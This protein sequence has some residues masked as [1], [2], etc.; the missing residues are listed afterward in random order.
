LYQNSRTNDLSPHPRTYSR[1][2]I[3]NRSTTEIAAD[4]LYAAVGGAS[5]TK[6]VNRAYLDHKHFQRYTALLLENRLLNY[7]DATKL[8]L[9]T[10]KGTLFLKI[11]EQMIE[12]MTIKEEGLLIKH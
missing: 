8:W 6:I 11:N 4:I 10:S 1:R 7:D 12:T 2:R 3:G 9:T 5:T